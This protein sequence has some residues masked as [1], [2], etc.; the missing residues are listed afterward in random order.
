MLILIVEFLI[1][2]AVLGCDIL[3][4]LESLKCFLIVNHV[5]FSENWSVVRDVNF[6]NSR[7]QLCQME[8]LVSISTKGLWFVWPFYWWITMPTWICYWYRDRCDK[9]SYSSI[10]DLGEERF[11]IAQF[12]DCYFVWWCD[13]V[14]HW[15]QNLTRSLDLFT[16][17]ICIHIC[18]ED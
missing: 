6:E 18:G 14:C 10:Q 12:V 15:L 7:W 16:R 4:N 8:L 11:G 17:K 9:I 5:W 13:G 2:V 1:S 3:I